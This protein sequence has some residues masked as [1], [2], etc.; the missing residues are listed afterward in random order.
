[1]SHFPGSRL[2]CAVSWMGNFPAD[3]EPHFWYGDQPMHLCV[4]KESSNPSTSCT[5]SATGQGNVTYS[6]C[7]AWG[8][9]AM[10][11]SPHSVDW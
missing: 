1:V 4:R 6:T 2:N 9:F 10:S 8:Y 7:L 3:R 11:D 5:A